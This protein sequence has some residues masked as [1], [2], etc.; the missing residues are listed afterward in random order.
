MA[1]VPPNGQAKSHRVTGFYSTKTGGFKSLT[2]N[3]Q[4]LDAIKDLD[5]GSQLWFYENSKRETETAPE[6]NLVFYT[7]EQVAARKVEW[8]AKK[9]LDPKAFSP[10]ANKSAPKRAPAPAVEEDDNYI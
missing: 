4:T 7:A 6:F 9:K 3:Q 10:S 5:I 1:Y 8:E 2:V